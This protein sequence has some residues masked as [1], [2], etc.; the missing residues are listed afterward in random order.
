MAAKEVNRAGTIFS[1]ATTEEIG[2]H[3]PPQSA[4]T[5]NRL[6]IL[7]GI[8]HLP[9]YALCKPRLAKVDAGSDTIAERLRGDLHLVIA[10]PFTGLDGEAADPEVQAQAAC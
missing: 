6:I 7:L 2:A 8:S 4:S 9:G 3:S 1:Q 5:G 10:S